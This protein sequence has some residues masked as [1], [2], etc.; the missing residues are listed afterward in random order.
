[1]ITDDYNVS[2]SILEAYSYYPFGL[3]QKG[4]GITAGSTLHNYKNT[5]QKQ[6]FKEDL[7]IDLYEFK[8]RIDDPQIGRFWQ[9]GPMADNYVYN[10]IWDFSVN[11]LTG[12]IKLEGLEDISINDV[13]NR[14]SL[15]IKFLLQPEVYVNAA[16]TFNDLVGANN[17]IELFTGK[18]S[19]SNFTE[20]KPRVNAA[21]E[22]SMVVVGPEFKAE[23]G[24]VKIATKEVTSG[25]SEKI[26]QT[27][28]KKN[29]ITGE[30]YSER[31]SGKASADENVGG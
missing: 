13:L 26:Y 7:G 20:D 14:S 22:L 17:A 30:V 19:E 5:F 23:G 1:M 10:S 2:S 28:T 11:H 24:V 4:I 21:I 18:R 8:Y 29:S 27:Y 25:V 3:Q 15:A 31:T 16:R 6:E 9:V 12:H